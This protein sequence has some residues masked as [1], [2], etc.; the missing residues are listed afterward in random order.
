MDE[1][2]LLWLGLALAAGVIE[3]FTL[4]LVLAMVAG[5]ALAAAAVAALTGNAIAAV[6]AFAVS[7]GLLLVVVRP[8]LLH[9]ASRSG[10]ATTTGVAALVGKPA[11]VVTPVTVRDGRVKL[12]GEIWTAR[13]VAGGNPL[14]AGSVVYVTQID[15]ATAVVSPLPPDPAALPDGGTAA[16]PDGDLPSDRPES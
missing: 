2:W 5:G 10:A 7:T 12:A 8:P 13:S 4:S 16:L 14:E 1:Q 3:V 15:G 11:E 9:Y 6:V